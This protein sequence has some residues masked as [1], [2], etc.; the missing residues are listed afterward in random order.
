MSTKNERFTELLENF[1]MNNND[2]HAIIVSDK[3]G[4]VINGV[5]KAEF[6]MELVSILSSIVN[7]ILDRIRNEFAFEKFG[8][9]AFDTEDFRLLFV[10]VT[11]RATLSIVLDSM[12]SVDRVSPYAYLLAEKTAQ[13][14]S[15]GEQADIQISIPTFEYIETPAERLKHQIYELKLD[16]GGIYRF[17]F[18]VIGEHEV[19]KTSLIRRYVDEKFSHDYRTTIGLNILTKEF[20]FFG[21]EVKLTLWDVGAQKFFKRF[22]KT[23]YTGA[24]AAF[25]VFDLTRK[26]T[27]DNVLTWYDELADFLPDAELPVVLVGN[28][29]DLKDQRKVTFKEGAEL[30]NKLSEESGISRI[31]YIE[32]SGT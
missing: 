32:T 19:G 7:P 12:A 18:I 30:A 14:L 21:N 5:K 1:L 20:E 26:E 10:S 28:K 6:D 22:R 8:T 3:Q 23:Y 27:F 16:S 9:A 13:F 4:L 11:N 15:P 31:S 25:I 24:Q 29:S 17:K 2:I